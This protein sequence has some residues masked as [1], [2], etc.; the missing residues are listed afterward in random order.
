MSELSVI[1]LAYDEAENVPAVLAE[2]VAWL[3]AHEP[4][5]EIVLVDDGSRDGTAEVA[6]RALEG[7]PHRIVR[8]EINRGIGAA[9]KTGVRAAGGEWITFLPA[10]GQIEPA[11][12]GTLRAAAGGVDLVLS[13]YADRDDG[14]DRKVLSFGVRAL[15]RAVHGVVLE[16][17]GPYLVRRRLFDPDDLPPDTFFLNFELPIRALA[18]GIPH[19][20]VTIR[21]RPRRAGTSKSTGFARVAGVARDLIDLR[22]RRARRAF[23]I[24]R[25]S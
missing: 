7:F 6:A 16:S 10:D 25:G 17:D 20:V 4:R 22:R 24:L 1:V 3:R 15:I 12:I 18:A 23:A 19:R 21:C 8:H 5:A 13:V 9:L 2:L 11:A 14:L